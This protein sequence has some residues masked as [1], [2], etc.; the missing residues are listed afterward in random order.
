MNYRIY[1]TSPET[2]EKG[3]LDP[4]G[5]DAL[6]EQISPKYLTFSG[7]VR[8]P[9]YFLFVSYMNRLLNEK[10]ISNK[11]LKERNEIKIRIE[12]LLVYCWKSQNSNLR[13]YNVIGNSTPKN[14]IDPFTSDGWRK[15]NCFK[16]YTELNYLPSSLNLYW[17]KTGEKQ[18]EILKDFVAQKRLLKTEQDTYLT[19]VRKALVSNRYS[20]FKDH[21]LYQRLKGTAKREL[22]KK[23]KSHNPNYF[24]YI[25]SFFE[26]SSF[27]EE[28]FWR[29]TLDN[30]KLPFLQLNQWFQAF[31]QAV[32]GDLDESRNRKRLW[33]DADH[34]YDRLLQNKLV[35]KQVSALGKRPNK[36][37]WFEKSNGL[38]KF[39]QKMKQNPTQWES[40]SRR[41]GEE[42]SKYF[43]TFRHAAL[44]SLIK[45]L[46]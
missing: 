22:Q 14:E 34:C 25:E 17:N 27:N 3:D 24:Q 41:Q 10:H 40:Y 46:N 1:V 30:P 35:G 5:F 29:V 16:I 11:T 38:Y 32:Q 45:E 8:K 20:L 2:F 19:E 4:F 28:K 39:S 6:S 21:L 23:L 37:N 44:A 26:D 36:E 7:T 9:S 42:N 31:V 13:G 33:Q 18:V 12:K 43:F 15:Q